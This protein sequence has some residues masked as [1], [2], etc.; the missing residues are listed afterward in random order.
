MLRAEVV[1]PVADDAAPRRGSGGEGARGEVEACSP[2]HTLDDRLRGAGGKID[3]E[4]AEHP[5]KRLRRG[6]PQLLVAELEEE[7]GPPG[8]LAPARH[9]G[10]V[11]VERDRD[12]VAERLVPRELRVQ[13]VVTVVGVGTSGSNGTAFSAARRA[14]IWRKTSCTR[15]MSSNVCASGL[16]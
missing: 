16:R 4:E 12:R 3:L 14:N 2:S 9:P 11:L 1:A 15:R 10:H 6:R 7:A 5:R 13:R 8:Q